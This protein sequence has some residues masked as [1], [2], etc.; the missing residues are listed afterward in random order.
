MYAEDDRHYD[1][2][3]WRSRRGM[4]ELDL[5]LVDFV[6]ARYSLLAC[7][8]QEAYRN[9]LEQ[10][11]WTIWEWLQR[12]ATPTAPFVRVVE[13]ITDF[14]TDGAPRRQRGSPTPLDAAALEIHD[15]RGT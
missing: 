6:R 12:R 9:L 3:L 4:L 8:D 10:D 2:V 15:D 7:A 14:V 11:D 5:L 1:R 13:L